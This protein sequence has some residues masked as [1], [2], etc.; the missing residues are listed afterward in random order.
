MS[1]LSLRTVFAAVCLVVA[2]A[3]IAF[4]VSAPFTLAGGHGTL[5][6]TNSD[7]DQ[8]RR[9]FSFSA[10]QGDGNTATG[11][12][13]LHNPA[14]TVENG[15]KY[16]LQV[17]ISCMNVFPDNIVIFGGSTQRTNDPTLVDAV[18]FAVQDNGEP[19]AG[20]DGISGVA[21]FDDDPNT[22]GDPARCIELSPSDLPLNT[23]DSGNIQ[24]K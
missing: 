14:F 17:D 16:M 23:I 13:I 2:A 11:N 12:A 1:S 18:F 24:V 6:V 15:Q 10:Q 21:F 9:Q 5:L 8:V 22:T 7:G 3:A 19:G 4:G 20:N